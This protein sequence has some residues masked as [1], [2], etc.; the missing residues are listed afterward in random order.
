MNQ[1]NTFA[2]DLRNQAKETRRQIEQTK[3]GI[4]SL[5]RD[6]ET[7]KD[8]LRQTFEA[9]EKEEIKRLDALEE[10]RQVRLQETRDRFNQLESHA[11]EIDNTIQQHIIHSQ[12]QLALFEEYLTEAGAPFSGDLKTPIYIPIYLAGLRREDDTTK[13]IVIPPLVVPATKRSGDPSL[14]QKTAPIGILAPTMIQYLKN[15]LE[16]ALSNDEKFAKQVTRISP[17]HNLLLDPQIE[18]LLYSG[19]HALWQSKLIP[20]RIHTQVK[21]ACIDIYRSTNGNS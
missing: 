8:K 20:E 7:R 6:A 14:G 3:R 2:V 13:L 18:S 12:N 1:F 9:Q 19:L 16:A 11:T 5:E 15:P 21:L 10:E 4:T 17:R